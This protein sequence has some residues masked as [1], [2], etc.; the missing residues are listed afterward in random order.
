MRRDATFPLLLVCFFLSGVAGLIYETAWTRQFSFVFGTSSLA[1]ATVLAAYMAGLAGGAGLASRYGHRV[2]RPV[3][4]YGLLELGIALAALAVPLA[5][6]ASRQLY[7]GLFGHQLTLA[8]AGGPSPALFYSICSFAILIVPTA[9]MGATLPLLVRYAVR[10]E[11]EIGHRIGVLYATNTAGAVVGTLV[12]A[13]ALLPYLGLDRTIWA[14]AAVNAAVFLAAW[15]LARFAAPAA[16]PA[17]V[18][19]QRAAGDA[20]HSRFAWL[21]PLVFGSGAV[22]F[23]YEVLWVRLLEHVLGGSVYAFANM[24][25]SFLA[26]IALGGALGSRLGTTRQRGVVGF[27]FAQLGAALL[28]LMAFRAIDRV[29]DIARSMAAAGHPQAASDALASIL[30]LLPA[31]ICIGAT[32]PLAVRAL[33]RDEFD[34]SRA[35]ARVY[36]WNTLGS[37]VG[38]IGA[39]FFLIP[40]L[41]YVRMIAVCAALNMALALGGALMAERRRPV[42]AAIACAALLATV[43]IP[44]RMPWATLTN[45]PIS[46]VAALGRIE[47]FGVG[48]SATVLLADS[49]GRWK[50]RTN[51]VP[52]SVIDPPWVWHGFYATARWLGLLPVLARPELESM[53]LIGLGG[54]VSI[55]VVPPG[56]RRIDV[57]ELE[58]EVVAAN[59]AVGDRRWR[60]PLADPRVHVHLDDARNAL[61]L[62]EQRFDAIVSQPSHPWSAGASHL[63]TREFFELVD[64]HLASDGAFVQWIGLPFIDELLFRSLLATLA[65]VFE[66]VRVYSPPPLTSVL[67]IASQSPLDVERNAAIAIASAPREFAEVGILIPEDVIAWWL[68]DDEGVRTLAGDAPINRDARNLL[69]SRAPYVARDQSRS[70]MSRLRFVVGDHDPLIEFASDPFALLERL[71]TYRATRLAGAGSAALRMRGLG[72]PVDR[73]VARALVEL[74]RGET[75]AARQRLAEVVR[76]DPRHAYARAELLRLSRRRLEQGLDPTAVVAAPLDPAELAVAE[77]WRL[78]GRNGGGGI[79]RLESALAA[80]PPRHPLAREAALLRTEWRLASGSPDLAREAIALV[81]R[82]IRWEPEDLLRRARVCAAA[83][84]PSA[85]LNS[86]SIVAG[87]LQGPIPN[88]RALIEE[89]ME[90]LASLRPAA[91][92]SAEVGASFA[93]IEARLRR[94]RALK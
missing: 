12:A 93:A 40:A 31:A 19:G 74:D 46:D 79:R 1:V 42:L 84:E 14:A 47:H 73:E 68:L 65:D 41:G 69:Q 7:V 66:H 44:P 45:S 51:G 76:E 89:A 28:S 22:S 15:A 10:S 86:L 48:R 54:G 50:L 81:D 3:L 56:V 94:L 21:L 78:S 87:Y 90:V 25:A 38:S 39:G 83:Q 26:G 58:P 29:P 72:R 85:A 67:F 27:A 35:S 24:L 71:P 16:P 4:A 36:A 30:T 32:Y 9:M 62:T 23:S 82:A 33:A 20:L 92:A 43:A 8:A 55:E 80:I 34:A 57:M 63:Y 5:I 53:L 60:D 75:E 70:V 52:E 77:A 61:L 17:P 88:A 2:R 49:E 59:R 18:S 64:E 37:I 6:Q 91:R 11:R 13:Y